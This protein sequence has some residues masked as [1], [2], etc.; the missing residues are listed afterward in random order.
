MQNSDHSVR[1]GFLERLARLFAWISGGLI[2]ACAILITLDV[3]ARDI[4][5][6]NF[7]ES[8]EI[9]IYTYAVT[10]AFSFAFAL[11]TK[12]HIRIDVIY[13]RFPPLGRALLDIVSVALLSLIAVIFCYYAWSTTFQ[14]LSFPGPTRL[15]AA[16]ASELAVPLVIPQSIWS[17][18][19]TWFAAICLIYLVRGLIS[20][21]RTDFKAVEALIGIAAHEADAEIDEA[22]HATAGKDAPGNPE[23]PH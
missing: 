11:T 2:L 13:A 15:G 8:F 10:V 3:F 23:H 16:S 20:L 6:D 7:F 4:F 5:N 14:S 18:G 17:L 1:E 12:T 19:L 21:A 22:L 9:T